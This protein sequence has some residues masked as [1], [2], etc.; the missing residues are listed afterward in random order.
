MN[1]LI[2]SPTHSIVPLHPEVEQ[3]VYSTVAT[4][5]ERQVT[6]QA[7]VMRILTA[8]APFITVTLIIISSYQGAVILAEM[9]GEGAKTPLN[10]LITVTTALCLIVGANV[11]G[12][13]L[14]FADGWLKWAGQGICILLFVWSAATSMLYLAAVIQ[15]SA[16]I[17]AKSE[18]RIETAREHAFA[19]SEI[20]KQLAYQQ[21]VE[22]YKGAT[23]QE[24]RDISSQVQA[25]QAAAQAAQSELDRRIVRGETMAKLLGLIA[26][27]VGISTEKLS[28]TFAFFTVLLMEL[29]RWYQSYQT[30][31]SIFRAVENR[32]PYN[33]VIEH[34]PTA[35][36]IYYPRTQPRPEVSL[37]K[38][39][40]EPKT[41]GKVTSEQP[42]T[43]PVSPM[44]EPEFSTV[45]A[46]EIKPEPTATPEQPVIHR[47]RVS[48]EKLPKP[49]ESI[50]PLAPVR[51]SFQRRLAKVVGAIKSGNL[52]EPTV[53]HINALL[54]GAG[55]GVIQK[56]RRELVSLNICER[57]PRGRLMVRAA[58]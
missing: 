44:R 55:M 23:G 6:V 26:G 30:G 3:S 4:T 24:S 57:G 42:E 50:Q 38:S 52:P 12:V 35:P 46:Q 8:L 29:L 48:L 2:K 47:P 11:I 18:L 58:K 19:A 10:Q 36:K 25:A 37:R 49:A 51:I 14:L 17:S 13:R 21:S 16:D 27:G 43:L 56:I 45:P 40:S 5:E 34:P 7:G 53:D 9:A 1:Q 32:R 41:A 39:V 22:A 31:A 20:A 54:G 33:V 28:L 15:S